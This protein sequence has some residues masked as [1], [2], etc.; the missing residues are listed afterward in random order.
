M[1][2]YLMSAILLLG[3]NAFSATKTYYLAKTKKN[4]VSSFLLRLAAEKYQ[5]SVT[6]TPIKKAIVSARLEVKG[7]ASLYLVEGGSKGACVDDF[8]LQAVDNLEEAHVDGAIYHRVSDELIRP[9]KNHV[10]IKSKIS[11]NSNLI[12][13]TPPTAEDAM[14]FVAILSG[15]KPINS[16]GKSIQDRRSEEN[17]KL[18]RDYLRR[19]YEKMGYTVKEVPFSQSGRNGINL[20]AEKSGSEKGFVIVSA[21]YDTVNCPGADDDGTGVATSLLLAKS[22]AHSQLKYGIQF[23]AFD[24]EEVGLVGSGAYAKHLASQKQMENLLGVFQVEMTGYNPENRNG[25]HIIDCEEN[26]SPELSKLVLDSLEE[27]SLPLKRVKAC[28]DRSDHAVFWSYNRPAIVVS[29]NFF[30]GDGNPCYHR[31]C[32]HQKELDH[33]YMAEIAHAVLG[34]I[35]KIILP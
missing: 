34:A 19:E 27:N 1:R 6:T 3:V 7:N 29:E 10:D 2:F 31:K 16:Q 9:L 13:L 23:V 20:V 24:L 18:A 26:T 12:G 8:C 25:I 4:E 5:Y 14:E 15:E 11:K 35:S 17:K 21:H 28:T 30:G 33:K 22:L 32:D